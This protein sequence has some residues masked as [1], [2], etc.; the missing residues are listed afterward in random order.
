MEGEEEEESKKVRKNKATKTAQKA[1]TTSVNT[2]EAFPSFSFMGQ[3][4]E[5]TSRRGKTDRTAE[6]VRE[7]TSNCLYKFLQE[8]LPHSEKE[9][10]RRLS[11]SSQLYS[12]SY[13][14]RYFHQEWEKNF[15]ANLLLPIFS[16][17]TFLWEGPLFRRKLFKSKR[18]LPK[19]YDDL[20]FL[21]LVERRKKLD[22]ELWEPVRCVVS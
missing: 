11:F 17:W 8:S 20:L 21:P 13:F 7:A 2:K 15:L 22:H 18:I 12:A 10:A 1:E 5:T 6:E 3:K 4:K 16:L 19:T 14:F 9:T